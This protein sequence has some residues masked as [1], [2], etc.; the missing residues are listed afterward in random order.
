MLLGF[1]TLDFLPP[2][3]TATLV[4]GIVIIAVLAILARWA[5]GPAAQI[6]RHAGLWGVRALTVLV[7]ALIL[8]NPVRV[9]RIPGAVDKP[10]VFVLMDASTSMEM[11]SPQSR[12]DT[13]NT[14]L[15]QAE[16]SLGN[17][18]PARLRTF[19]FGRALTSQLGEDKKSAPVEKNVSNTPVADVRPTEGDTRIVTALRQAPNRFG[20]KPPQAMV[21][22]SDGRARDE[23]GLEALLAQYKQWNIPIHV[24]PMGEE[25][26][27]GDVA[28]VAAVMP[29]KARKSSEVEAHV[30]LR[31]YG[32]EGKRA[33]VTVSSRDERDG[34]LRELTSTAVTL[35]SG[36]QAAT[37]RFQS[38]TQ[39]LKLVMK[40]NE[41]PEEISSLNN[42]FDADL[43]IDRTK[44]RVLY[45]EGNYRS[46]RQVVQAD[47]VEYRGPYSE[48]HQALSSDED[49]ECVVVMAPP[50]SSRTIRIDTLNNSQT[51]RGFP[52]TAAELSAFDCI[53]LSNVDRNVLTDKQLGW[54]K[55]WIGARGGGLLMTGGER[56]F[57]AGGWADSVVAEM[58]P[59]EIGTGVND[60]R[61]DVDALIRPTGTVANHPLWRILGDASQNQTVI[62]AMPAYHGI[63]RWEKIKPAIAKVLGESSSQISDRPRTAT[64]LETLVPLVTRVD[65]NG[66]PVVVPNVPSANAPS[67]NGTPVPDGPTPAFVLGKYGKG[68]TAAFAPAITSPWAD[69]V[70]TNWGRGDNRYY[71]KFWRNV[72][73]WLTEDSSIGRRRLV[74]RCDKRFYRPGDVIS[75]VV[76]AYDENANPTRDYRV[77]AN[78]EQPSSAPNNDSVFAPVRWPDELERISGE[79]GPFILWGEEF[80]LQ[81][82]S[83][84]EDLKSEK[85]YHA[86][87]PL[88][89][90]LSSGAASQ[91]IRIELTAQEDQTQVDSTSMEIHILHDP[92]EQHNPFPNHEFLKSIAQKTGGKVLASPAELTKLLGDI[93]IERG[94]DIVAKS[95]IWS[96]PWLLVALLALMTF[97][98]VWR[99]AIGLA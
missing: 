40:V 60:W 5:T 67:A 17:S 73:Y 58:L 6:S 94:P 96:T 32:Y 55:R 19:F 10:D 1:V 34:E 38:G 83:N 15:A 86:K 69:D 11:G 13:A 71:A 7:L 3:S 64:T 92:F 23:V 88:V 42:Q 48:L 50:G 14:W 97:E 9:D 28:I 25:G 59:V 36:F 26:K 12:W 53:I 22:M 29:T 66:V 49:I 24:A 43:G 75:I 72:V 87:L 41:Q 84:D 27:G 81:V 99:R 90:Q 31:S 21:L 51:G 91:R 70:N 35:T 8:F 80:D 79:T 78:V 2:W 20:R 57:A 47:R 45:V 39:P 82:S 85:V 44:I 54:L 61:D 74:A 98:W 77:S 63:N 68:R 4:G 95:P 18:L 65:A 62:D 16:K 93:P 37:L 33:T 56:S 52:E 46:F 76:G 30:F 89:E